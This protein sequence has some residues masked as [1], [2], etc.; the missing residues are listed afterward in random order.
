MDELGTILGVWA[1]PDDEAY[2]SAGLM[3]RAVRNGSRVACVTATRGEGGSMDEEQWPSDRMGEVRTEELERSLAIL[4]VDEHFWLDLPDI[5][6]Q[7]GLPEDG[8]ERVR[9]LVEDVRPD[10]IL[11][12]GPDGM[13]GHE[14]HK[15][16]SRWA[17]EAL[18]EVGR[19][20]AR[21]LFACVTPEWAAEFLPVW[22]PFDT[23]LPGTPVVVPRAELVVDF[24][25]PQDLLSL[26][27]QAINAHVSQVEAIVGAVGEET[28][29]RQ[30][31]WEGFRL[32]E[33][34][35]VETPDADPS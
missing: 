26:K 4:G 33:Q 12:F 27:V 10:T 5:D 23:F 25:I 11:T 20:G 2:L 15:S 18:H 9:D 8:Y 17:V 30:M 13:T 21:V 29:W 3:A 28:W 1:H 19:P 31:S 7:T 22:E 24:P 32:G 35:D 16:V 34:R 6:M 14:A